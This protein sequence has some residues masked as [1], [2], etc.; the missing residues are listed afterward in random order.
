MARVTA[1]TWSANHDAVV[2]ASGVCVAMTLLL[3]LLLS[4]LR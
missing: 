1:Q 4:L 2:Y 3:S